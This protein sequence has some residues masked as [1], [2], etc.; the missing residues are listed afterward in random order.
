M[1]DVAKEIGEGRTEPAGKIIDEEG[2]PIWGSLGAVGGDDARGWMP[3]IPPPPVFTPHRGLKESRSS[4]TPTI[5]G[6]KADCVRCTA[7]ALS[8]GS[9]APASLATPLPWV[10]FGAMAAEGGGK[11]QRTAGTQ[12]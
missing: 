12:W 4:N 2:V 6:K 3:R 9:A 5:E 11:K 1:H 7:S 8:D 10:D